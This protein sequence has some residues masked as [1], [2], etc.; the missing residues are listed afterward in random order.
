M[1]KDVYSRVCY[2][3]LEKEGDTFPLLSLDPQTRHINLQRSRPVLGLLL[4]KQG[5]GVEM[6][7][8]VKKA[9]SMDFCILL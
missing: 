2:Y 8:Y 5:K 6:S 4:L 9:N 1:R 3:Q 7:K